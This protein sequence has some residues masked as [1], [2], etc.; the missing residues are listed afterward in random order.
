MLT[1]TIADYETHDGVGLIDADDGRILIFSVP[2][3]QRRSIGVGK[4]V[5]FNEQATPV[6][7][8][9]ID[10]KPLRTTH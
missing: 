6:S 4:R 3:E 5:E 9:A 10:V 8:R 1:G 7:P 2:P